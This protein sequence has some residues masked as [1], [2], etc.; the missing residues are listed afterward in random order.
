[1]TATDLQ[2][3]IQTLLSVKKWMEQLRDL[4]QGNPDHKT[5]W[6]LP[7]MSARYAEVCAALSKTES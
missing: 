7:G 6:P 3:A 1:M 4:H 2:E 5:A